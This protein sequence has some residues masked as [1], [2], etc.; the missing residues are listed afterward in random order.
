MKIVFCFSFFLL[1]SLF[2]FFFLTSNVIRNQICVPLERVP[3][4][5]GVFFGCTVCVFSE[6]TRRKI[7]VFFSPS[8]F[9]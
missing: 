1:F 8:F 2:S 4:P 7:S 9:C 5:W 3:F 6:V